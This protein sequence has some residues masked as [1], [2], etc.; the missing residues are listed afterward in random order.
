VKVGQPSGVLCTGGQE[1]A[2]PAAPRANRTDRHI[3]MLHAEQLL[4]SRGVAPRPVAGKWRA[5]ITRKGYVLMMRYSRSVA[6]LLARV[7]ELVVR[8][9]NIR[10]T[11]VGECR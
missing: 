5:D 4:C 6:C 11:T 7:C 9:P 8:A 1:T 10:F 3:C 2:L